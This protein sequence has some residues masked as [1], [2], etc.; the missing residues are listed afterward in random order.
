MRHLDCGLMR[1]GA[2]HNEVDDTREVARD[3]LR[4]FALADPDIAG[5]EINRMAAELRHA[6][7]EGDAR[8]QR[9]LLENHRESFAAQMRM[10][11][12]DFQFGLEPGREGE[13]SVKFVGL[14]E[15]RSRKSRFMGRYRLRCPRSWAS[16]LPSMRAR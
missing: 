2:N 8:T 9:G 15:A 14:S 12:A 11:Q 6:G 7:F 10:L 16:A 5:R 13:Q 1:E 4:R 3:I